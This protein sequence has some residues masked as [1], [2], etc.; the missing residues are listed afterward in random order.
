MSQGIFL[1]S[2]HGVSGRNAVFEDD[3]KIAFLYLTVPGK[4][5]PERDAIVYS[6]IPPIERIDWDSI[7]KTGGTP[8]LTKDLA[9]TSAILSNPREQDF[10]FLW[11]RDGSAVALLRNGDPIAFVTAH[12]R[13]G[14]SK[15]VIKT[16]PFAH[17]WDQ[18]AYDSIFVH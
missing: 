14:Y 17:A 3:E 18:L 15:A 13:F 9:S 1:Q 12:G 2:H 11:S 8:L 16:S 7:K 4:I 6:R 5:Q 10:S